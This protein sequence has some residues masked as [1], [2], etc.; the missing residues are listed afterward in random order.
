MSD[1]ME[2]APPKYAQI[3]QAL[4]RRITDGTYPEGSQLPSETQLV[5]EFGVSRPTVVRALQAMQLRGEIDRE[6]G[7]GSYVKAT[8]G[9]ADIEQS[10]PARS[11]LDHAEAD[12]SVRVTAAE[13]RDAPDYVARL[14]GLAE[15]APVFLRQYIG[16]RADVT[17]TLVSLWLP[18]SVAR[19][20]GLDQ[21]EPL[22]APVRRLV[23]AGTGARLGQVVERLSARLPT[24]AEAESLHIAESA[25]VF[26]VLATVY[27]TTRR[28]LLVV[29]LVLPGELHDLEETYTL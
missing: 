9:A 14:L 17:A 8:T 25:P 22:T 19:S 26:G 10:R 13:Q 20:G 21:A 3:V 16:L 24:G 15:S 7:R 12:D 28:P 5:R 1:D 2:Y 11:A 6:H 27:D 29:E 18:V 23:Q 4:R